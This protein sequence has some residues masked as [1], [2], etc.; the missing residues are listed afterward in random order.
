MEVIFNCKYWL[1][2]LESSFVSVDLSN[3]QDSAVKIKNYFKDST[4]Q[5]S[6][7][8]TVNILQLFVLFCL[9]NCGE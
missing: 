3:C 5:Q 9:N 2:D 6:T 1:K 8:K 4:Y 7:K